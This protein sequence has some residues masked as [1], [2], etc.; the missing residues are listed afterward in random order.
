MKNFA[1]MGFCTQENSKFTVTDNDNIEISNLN[2]Q[3]LFRKDDVGHPKSVVAI[4]SIQEM[5]PSF[6]AEG[7]VTKVSK[8]TEAIFYICSRFS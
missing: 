4:K 2:R 5:N 8:E 3:F 7:K 1:M 6:K